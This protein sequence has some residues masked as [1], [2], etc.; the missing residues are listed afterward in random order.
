MPTRLALAVRRSEPRM[1]CYVAHLLSE[2]EDGP[3]ELSI[4]MFPEDGRLRGLS[5]RR[6][7]RDPLQRGRPAPISLTAE[8]HSAALVTPPA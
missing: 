8:R 3:H 6:G 7:W 4:D 1:E 2:D 5:R